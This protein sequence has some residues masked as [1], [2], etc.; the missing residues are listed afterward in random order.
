MLG[1]M[2]NVSINNKAGIIGGTS[3][4]LIITLSIP[5]GDTILYVFARVFETF[6]GVFVAILVNSDVD[7]VR[8]WLKNKNEKN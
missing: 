8:E 7:M 4:L 2:I 3:A 5:A 1:I 6:C